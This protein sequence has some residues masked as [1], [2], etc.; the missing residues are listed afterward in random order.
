MLLA[1]AAWALGF[2]ALR[3]RVTTS[4]SLLRSV[5]GLQRYDIA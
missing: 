1:F 2:W 5:G 3:R 4:Q